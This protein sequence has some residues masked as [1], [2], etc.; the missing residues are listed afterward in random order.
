MTTHDNP[1]RSH[2]GYRL[3]GGAPAQALL[4]VLGIETLPELR[5]EIYDQPVADSATEPLPLTVQESSVS[6]DSA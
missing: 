6:S 4:E 3:N 2:R 1:E 5:F